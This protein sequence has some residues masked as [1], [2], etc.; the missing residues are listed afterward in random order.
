M[1]RTAVERVQGQQEQQPTA[2]PL[3][4]LVIGY[5]SPIRGDDAL[6]PLVA[7]RLQE[8]FNS[9]P[10]T[11]PETASG[12]VEVQARHILTA[13]LVDDL[14][15]TQRVIF[16]DAAIDTPPGQVRRRRLSPDR[17]ALS[18]M[19]H[20]H[21]PRE[22]LAW[23][24]ALYQRVPEAWLVSGGGAEWGYAC[25]ALSETAQQA[26]EPMIAEVMALI[27]DADRSH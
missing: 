20:F 21:D 4:A 11:Q 25:Y 14:A 26:L 6:G 5:G 9:Q 17:S 18:T 3:R 27:D 24:E 16:V 12:V 13:E 23:C 1:G 7:D 22:L 15:R 8:R 10:A 2:Q 19:A